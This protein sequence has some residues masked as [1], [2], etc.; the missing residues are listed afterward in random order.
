VK[1]SE[2]GLSQALEPRRK[3]PNQDCTQFSILGAALVA[4]QV[5]IELQSI[6]VEGEIDPG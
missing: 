3:H 6:I 5:S 2:L 4:D 1:A